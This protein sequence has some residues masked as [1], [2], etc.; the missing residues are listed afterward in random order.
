MGNKYI[1]GIDQSTQGTKVL[2][3]DEKGK[4]VDKVSMEHRQIIDQQGWVE[5]DPIE[6]YNNTI[7]LVKK[8]I[9]KLSFAPSCIL[10]VGLTNQRETA[11]VWDKETGKPV[12]NA[13]VWQCAR[14]AEIC[15]RIE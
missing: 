10:G 13:I 9:E 3:F 2:L 7:F 8:L 6:I 11:L 1:L 15:K 12:Y 4:I 5:H 14:A